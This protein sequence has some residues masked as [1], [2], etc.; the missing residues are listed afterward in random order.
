MG[1]QM[2]NAD[3]GKVWW[4]GRRRGFGEVVHV[5]EKIGV[6]PTSLSECEQRKRARVSEKRKA[7]A[8]W[9][10]KCYVKR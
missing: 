10:N 8:G 3:R 4:D 6:D 7:E 1:N 9:V 5:T 2:K